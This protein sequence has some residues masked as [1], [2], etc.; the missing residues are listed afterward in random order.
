[1]T[2][3]TMIIIIAEI[4]CLFI[5]A[6]FTRKYN[7]CNFEGVLLNHT[8]NTNFFDGYSTINLTFAIIVTVF[9]VISFGVFLLMFLNKGGFIT[10]IGGF[11]T[12]PGL[13]FLTVLAIVVNIT[14]V[15]VGKDNWYDFS[16]NWMFYIIVSLHVVSTVFALLIQFNKFP[17]EVPVVVQPAPA[18]SVSSAGSPDDLKKYKELLDMGA[19]TQEEFDA[20]KKQLLGL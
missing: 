17:S 8:E 14:I 13:I 4:T 7:F 12:I 10:K 19:I 16:L 18:A 1:M 2:L 6:V 3:I 11:S 20:K 5:P 9:L 15:D